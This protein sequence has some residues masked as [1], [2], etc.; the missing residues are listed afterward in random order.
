MMYVRSCPLFLVQEA[1]VNSQCSELPALSR[2]CV[3]LLGIYTEI[4]GDSCEH[5]P[6]IDVAIAKDPSNIDGLD[7]AAMLRL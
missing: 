7:F 6:F 4:A 1:R 2:V 5:E 3:N